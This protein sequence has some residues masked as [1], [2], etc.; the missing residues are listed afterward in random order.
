MERELVRERNF[1][2]GIINFQELMENRFKAVSKEVETV[3]ALE[4]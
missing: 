4:F 3:E 2:A 1:D